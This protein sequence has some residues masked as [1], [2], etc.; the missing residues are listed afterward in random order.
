[1][2][3]HSV[4]IQL[5][6]FGKLKEIVGSQLRRLEIPAGLSIDGVRLMLS[7]E[8]NEVLFDQIPLVY[9]V[10]EQFMMG[11]TVLKEGDELAFMTPMSGG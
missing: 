7:R 6:F 8:S 5:L 9:A 11:D 3:V 1:M 4:T 2:T 10:N